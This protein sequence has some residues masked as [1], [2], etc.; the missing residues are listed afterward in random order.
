MTFGLFSTSA[1]TNKVAINIHVYIFL[2][3]YAFIYL[4]QIANDLDDMVGMCLICILNAKVFFEFIASFY[5]PNRSHIFCTSL[6]SGVTLICH[7]NPTA[8]K[9]ELTPRGNGEPCRKVKTS[10]SASGQLRRPTTLLLLLPC[11]KLVLGNS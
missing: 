7:D 11:S 10:R 1:I 9:S 4:E 6:C 5:F 3:M 8:C 2:L